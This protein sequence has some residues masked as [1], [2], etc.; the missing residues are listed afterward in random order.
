MTRKALPTFKNNCNVYH[1]LWVIQ[2]TNVIPLISWLPPN[3]VQKHSCLSQVDTKQLNSSRNIVLNLNIKTIGKC[4][5]LAFMI[6]V[7]NLHSL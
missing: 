7:T 1:F 2:Q 6:S 5:L 3:V 4:F